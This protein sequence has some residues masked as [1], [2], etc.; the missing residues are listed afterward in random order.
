[1]KKNKSIALIGSW[2]IAYIKLVDEF[3]EEGMSAEILQERLSNGGSAY[4]TTVNIARLDSHI[5]L[6]A[7][8]KI[9]CDLDGESILDDLKSHHIS[10]QCIEAT[11]ELPT[12]YDDVTSVKDTARCTLF[13]QKGANDL[14]SKKEIEALP[15]NID[16]HYYSSLIQTPAV[17]RELFQ[18]SKSKGATVIASLN[19]Q[20][21]TLHQHSF[22]PALSSVDILVLGLRELENLM[23]RE[24]RS[25]GE[26]DSQALASIVK[27]LMHL[28]NLKQMIVIHFPEGAYACTTSEV[29]YWEPSLFLPR[30]KTASTY[31]AGDAFKAGFIT[32]FTQGEEIQNSLRL[33]HA[34]AAASMMDLSAS[35]GVWSSEKC[36]HLESKFPQ[37]PVLISQELH[38]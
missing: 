27:N 22:I 1:M 10:T 33:G 31:G 15:S 7:V 25:D 3:P 12:G 5:P 21:S 23:D 4:N 6:Y 19:R 9:G 38:V 24:I 8:G 11:P 20:E 17:T 36:L 14:L 29:T 28:G 35:G 16:F 34:A 37:R 26:I 30:S 2:S 18:H 32:A 13:R